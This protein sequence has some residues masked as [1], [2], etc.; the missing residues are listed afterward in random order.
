MIAFR[1]CKPALRYAGLALFTLVWN[2]RCLPQEPAA[3]DDDLAADAG[4]LPAQV[5]PLPSFA[6]GPAG[7]EAP[8]RA[9]RPV[10]NDLTDERWEIEVGAV[11]TRFR[12]S[13]Y[14]ASMGGFRSSLA[15]HWNNWFAAEGGVTT[16]FAPAIL[17]NEPVKYLDYM[18][19]VRVGPWR[20]RVSPWVHGQIGG[21]HQ[22]PRLGSQNSFA[23]KG[24]V[25]VDYF[26]HSPLSLRV[27]ADWVQ[28]RFFHETQNHFQ[29]SASVV[30]RF[31]TIF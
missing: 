3:R 28:T 31:N 4:I 23:M 18:A 12:S 20:D 14:Y 25:G 17:T 7:K 2:C 9:Q 19:G 27:Q 21:A 13:I 16:G 11:F 30:I 5:I 8:R 29:A 24:G 26:V 22:V 10:R 15:Y 1:M 6:S